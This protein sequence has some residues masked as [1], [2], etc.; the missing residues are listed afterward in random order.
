MS[1]TIFVFAVSAFRFNFRIWLSTPEAWK[2]DKAVKYVMISC[3][4]FI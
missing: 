1:S 3:F 4:F 2:A